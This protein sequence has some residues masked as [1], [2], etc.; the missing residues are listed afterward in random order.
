MSGI[1]LGKPTTSGSA[2]ASRVDRL[3][4]RAGAAHTLR[5]SSMRT[6]TD[7]HPV[8]TCID[9]FRFGGRQSSLTLVSR[10]T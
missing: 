2:Q 10:M 7:G 6:L 3:I 1:A 5:R 9:R 4:V 8:R